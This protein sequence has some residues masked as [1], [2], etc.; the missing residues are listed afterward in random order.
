MSTLPPLYEDRKVLNDINDIV[1]L[2]TLTTIKRIANN[3]LTISDIN[4]C[5]HHR[6]TPCNGENLRHRIFTCFMND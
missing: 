6:L 4:S 1:T 3:H 5:Y 2:M